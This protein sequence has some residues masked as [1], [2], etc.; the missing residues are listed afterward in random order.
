MGSR[1]ASTGPAIVGFLWNP[2]VIWDL[3]LLEIETQSYW[4]PILAR[5]IFTPSLVRGAFPGGGASIVKTHRGF[6]PP[7]LCVLILHSHDPEGRT[8][9]T[10]VIST[11]ITWNR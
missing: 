6:R 1:V 4:T 2:D 3:L 10:S 9:L 7:A 11:R 5:W 8:R